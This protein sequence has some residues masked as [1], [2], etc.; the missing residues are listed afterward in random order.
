MDAK[1]SRELGGAVV[2]RTLGT[3]NPR[4]VRSQHYMSAS[5]AALATGCRNGR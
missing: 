5:T 2:M 3:G 1:N 4:Q